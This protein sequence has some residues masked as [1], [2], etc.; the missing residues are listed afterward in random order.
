[1]LARPAF[2]VSPPSGGSPRT[3]VK[4]RQYMLA[5]QSVNAARPMGS[6]FTRPAI[7]TY[8]PESDMQ[9]QPRLPVALPPYEVELA[10]NQ[11]SA[12]RGG[13][14]LAAALLLS[15][16]LLDLAQ[17]RSAFWRLLAVRL[18]AAAILVL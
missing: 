15:F 17:A 4:T 7:A 1:S 9:S 12:L 11:R 18:V 3:L 14:L 5:R 16:A 8:C 2:S 6:R 13:A 10:A